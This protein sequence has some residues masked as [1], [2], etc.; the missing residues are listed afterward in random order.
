MGTLAVYERN[1][2]HAKQRVACA[3]CEGTGYIECGAC[4]GTGSVMS[5]D[6]G[7]ITCGTCHG[8]SASRR[9]QPRRAREREYLLGGRI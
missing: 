3:Y 1:R 6:G 5:A 4:T 2:F 7:V 8:T 9:A